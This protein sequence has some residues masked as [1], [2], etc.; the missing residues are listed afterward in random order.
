MIQRPCDLTPLRAGRE[1]ESQAFER[2]YFYLPE[3]V[4]LLKVRFALC[5]HTSVSYSE[6][7]LELRAV[8][9]CRYGGGKQ[10]HGL[11]SL[12]PLFNYSLVKPP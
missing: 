3:N 2:A 10:K 5:V 9:Q 11:R 6:E 12:P 4:C 8:V 1:K 7:L